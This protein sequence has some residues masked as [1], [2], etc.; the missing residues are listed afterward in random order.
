MDRRADATGLAR[1]VAAM[2]PDGE[3]V[4]QHAGRG[5]DHGAWVPL[6]AMYPL[7]DI[8]VLQLSLPAHDPAALL[9]LAAR[10]APLREGG[11]LVIGSG[12][13][14]HGL[15]FVTREML[16]GAVPSSAGRTGRTARSSTAT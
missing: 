10:L 1:R 16:E 15:P 7:A 9:D 5:L 13:M 12:F 11:V 6:M 3:P 8:P 2:M 4:H 14:T